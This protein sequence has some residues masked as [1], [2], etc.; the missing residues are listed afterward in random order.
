MTVLNLTEGLGFIEAGIKMSDDVH[1]NKRR[2]STSRGE[3][4]GE[5]YLFVSPELSA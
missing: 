1:S 3:P 5:E 2:A 4:E